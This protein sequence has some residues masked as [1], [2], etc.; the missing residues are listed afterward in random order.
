MNLHDHMSR[1]KMFRVM[2][3]A[4]EQAK[5]FEGYTDK[6][7]FNLEETEYFKLLCEKQQKHYLRGNN[8]FFKNQDDLI[9]AMGG[10]VDEFRFRYRFLSNHTHSYPMGFY[11]MA[12]IGRG[13]G[14]ESKSE[15]GCIGMCLTWATEYLEKAK[16]GFSGLFSSQP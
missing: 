10:S 8:A 2:D 7:K 3:G 6:V 16:N 13:T 4:D 1:L 5:Q 11:R 14:M 15:V 12:E 9:E